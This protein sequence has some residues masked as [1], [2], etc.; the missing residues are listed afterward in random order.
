MDRLRITNP[1]QT[2]DN[3]VDFLGQTYETADK[4]Q[5]VIAVSGGIDS[6]LA[7]VL[8]ARALGP[9]KIRPV[10]LPYGD[11]DLTDGHKMMDFA[12]I[13]APNREVIDITSIVEAATQAVGVDSDQQV[14]RGN[15]MARAR[16]M[17]IYDLAKQHNA[18]VCGTENKSEKYLGYF[19][20][21]GDEASDVE[22]LIGLYK[23]Q[24]RQLAE[25]LELPESVRTKAPSAGLWA[26]QTDEQELGFDYEVADLVLHQLETSTELSGIDLAIVQRVMERVEAMGF[27][28]R[29]PYVID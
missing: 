21:F 3:I 16:M 25:F 18:L 24:V 4:Q 15:L 19:T 23:T 9:D 1:Q 22:P 27:K 7:L 2:V 13:P 26:G 17:V 20:R 8:V 5:A 6:G 29:V 14:R 12:H 28:N 10:L 11:Q